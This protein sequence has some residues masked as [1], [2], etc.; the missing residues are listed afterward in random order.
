MGSADSCWE[1]QLELRSAILDVRIVNGLPI[2][3]GSGDGRVDDA[4]LG[5]IPM[6]GY[7]LR[8]QVDREGFRIEPRLSR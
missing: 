8:I 6:P 1:H 4:A 3:S 5:F 7:G 2:L